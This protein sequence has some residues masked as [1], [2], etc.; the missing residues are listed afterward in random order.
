[1]SENGKLETRWRKKSKRGVSPII[2]TILLVAIT[3]VLAA[4]L[5]VLISGLAK[6]PGNTPLGSAWALGTPTE[7][8]SPGAATSTAT[9][10][11]SVEQASSGITVGSVSFVIKSSGGTPLAASSFAVTGATAEAITATLTTFSGT[12]IGVYSFS[13]NTWGSFGTGYTSGTP[14]TPGMVLTVT[15]TDTGAAM[16]AAP[17]L[18]GQGDFL[19]TVGS[20]SFSGTVPTNIP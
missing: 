11:F 2:A 18:F 6:G 5:Y 19:S 3:V 10:V 16:T 9:A 1:M 20:G 15:V 12:T 14:L 17:A 7:S 8:S 4:V 13:T